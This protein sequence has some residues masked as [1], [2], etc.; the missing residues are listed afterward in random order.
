MN[1]QWKAFLQSRSARIDDDEGVTFPGASLEPDC[2]LMDLSH[3]GLI[4]VSGSEA[5]TFLQGQV[6][7]DIVGLSPEHSQ[8]GSHCSPKGRVLASF[9][10]FKIDGTVYL[11]L[12]RTTVEAALQRLRM[13]V[14]RADAA[15][16]D[17]SD[18]LTA[19]AVAGGCAG[20]LLSPHLDSVPAQDNALTRAGDLIAIRIPGTVPRFQILGPTASM[21]VLWDRLAETATPANADYWAILD[22]RAGIPS[23]YPQTSDAFVPQM[24]NLQLLD[25]ISF[26]KGCYTGQE[27]V[28]R[29]QY[30]GKLKRRMY[31]AQV[32][33]E[34]A[35]LPGDQLYCPSS[36]S[37]QATGRVVDARP[38]RNGDYE[39]LVVVEIDSA[40]NSEVRL[41][42]PDGPLLT[43]TPP[44][45]GFPAEA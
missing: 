17:A 37:E 14:L 42:G 7:N 20:S 13:Y 30:L 40:E 41:G 5:E 39:L 29:M 28:A 38:N 33:G 9:R 4:A 43:F 21:E 44:P 25:G 35:P 45:Y 6:T 24:A 16:E 1:S 3:L 26:N 36:S 22:I 34:Q 23:V 12:P 10:A 2:A 11:Q 8:L 15:I 18:R 32:S 27:V 19:I 31:L